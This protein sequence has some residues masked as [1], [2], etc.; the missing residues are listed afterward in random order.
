MQRLLASG[1]QPLPYRITEG[2][3]VT[4]PRHTSPIPPAPSAERIAQGSS[5]ASD[6]RLIFST[7]YASSSPASG[8]RW[9]RLNKSNIRKRPSR[10]HNR[11]LPDSGIL[12]GC[13]GA[14]K[15]LNVE[16]M[17]VDLPMNCLRVWPC[18]GC[19]ASAVPDRRA[20]TSGKPKNCQGT[21]PNTP[22]SGRCA[23]ALR[24]LPDATIV[25]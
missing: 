13:S 20:P 10:R 21:F 12:T 8:A 9:Y 7:P 25:H 19:F 22:L 5:L 15:Q 14:A 16:I 24:L 2:L 23:S 6:A 11:C 4:R 1:R 17:G 3:P 18:D